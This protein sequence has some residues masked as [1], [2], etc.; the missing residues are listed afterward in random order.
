VNEGGGPEDLVSG[1][2]CVDE[3]AGR[4]RFPHVAHGERGVVFGGLLLAQL[5]LAAGRHEG[6][7]ARSVKSVKS[8]KSAHGLFARPVLVDQEMSVTVEVLHSGRAFSSAA[9]TM[10]Q[11]ERA[12]ATALVLLHAPERD[13]I[14][15]ASN[16]PKTDGPDAATPWA[17]AVPGREIRTVGRI[18]ILDADA[19]GPPEVQL[20]VRVRGA[21]D[22]LLLNQA[23]LAHASAG[24]LIG[25]AMRP[26]EGIG[27]SIAHRAISTGILGHTISF[28]DQADL[29]DWVLLT[30]E[31]TYAGEGRA[32]GRGQAFS[33]AGVLVASFSQEAMI[34]HFPD[35]QSAAGREST[36]F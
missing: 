35:G 3:G 14:R 8:V 28:H 4:Y 23:L 1:L 29:R 16:P 13:L 2:H 10:W 7:G 17:D 19:L 31:S 12:C 33:R 36:V 9:V 27:Q 15:H 24:F 26:H 34:R 22:D 21:T 18:D 6:S 32:F 5:A 30:N 11:R 20:W 25:A